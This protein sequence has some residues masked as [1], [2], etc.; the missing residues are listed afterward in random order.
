[1]TFVLFL[2][3]ALYTIYKIS[4]L[5]SKIDELQNQ[6]SLNK[7]S[8]PSP[9]VNTSTARRA[10]P[11]PHLTTDFRQAHADISPST[12]PVENTSDTP[13]TITRFFTWFA[14]D[15]PLK[16][17][18]G[19]IILGF[20]WLVSYAFLNNWIGETGRITLGLIAG[21]GILA[22]G[23]QW[24]R[25]STQQG[26]VLELLGAGITLV[27]IFAAQNIYTMFPPA[28]ALLLS[29]AVMI[30]M[31]YSAFTYNDRNLALSALFIA[32][33][34]PL[35]TGST[36]PNILS[37]YSYLMAISIGTLWV[38]R[39]SNWNFLT[40]LSLGIITLYSLPYFFQSFNNHTPY[41]LLQLKFFA[42]S[43]TSLFFFSSIVNIIHST[44][45]H[46]SDLATALSIGLFS[47]AWI[48]ALA[49]Q[50]YHSLLAL[51]L[52]IIFSLTTQYVYKLT[53]NPIPIYIYAGNA[54]LLLT[55]ATAYQ[56]EGPQ[57]VIAF[58]LISA[59]IPIFS[60]QFLTPRISYRLLMYFALPIVLSVSSIDSS[61]WRTG[62]L[63]ADFFALLSITVS[64]WITGL[65]I[66]QKDQNLSLQ[67]DP[68][69]ST[70]YR[71]L[72]IAAAIYTLILIWLVNHST[73]K[74]QYLARM[75]TLSLYTLIGLTA[76]IQGQIRIM[77]FLYR[78]GQIIT[79]A[80]IGWLLLIEVW[81]MQLTGRII[82][83]FS[84]GILL[85]GSVL[86]RKQIHQPITE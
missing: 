69:T 26:L 14:I 8:S 62:F 32:G 46:I 3:F 17:G 10:V 37:L 33:I 70:A 73:L 56:F 63:H 54:L 34:A 22:A 55:A 59:I 68:E 13:D 20:A 43:F 82:T 49:P 35:L 72:L 65:Y 78:F 36:E 48:N 61:L 79:L 16:T 52:A 7:L 28:V 39:H 71:F 9:T 67:D 50:N 53:Q 23:H 60:L 5:E 15:W 18:A 31:T 21:S 12:Y 81:D 66:Y 38:S 80:V 77:P 41:E 4:R 19:L 47:L 57:L 76:Y 83:F 11:S 25:K 58:S 30:Y 29:C 2:I 86:I 75:V 85:M 51:S 44:R 74:P 27:T 40:P 1:M 6:R 42:V 64:L 24:M 84:I 45:S